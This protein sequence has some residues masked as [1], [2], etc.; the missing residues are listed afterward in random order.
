MNNESCNHQVLTMMETELDQ[1][2]W[3]PQDILK[4]RILTMVEG[5]EGREETLYAF[6]VRGVILLPEPAGV[7][8][9]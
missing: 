9:S 2:V 1:A 6:N 4:N 3:T 7:A 8:A 5:E